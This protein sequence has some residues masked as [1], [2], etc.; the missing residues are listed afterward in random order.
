MTGDPDP[1]PLTQRHAVVTFEQLKGLRAKGYIRDSTLDQRDGFGPD[2]QRRN[3]Q[4]FA[5]SYGLLLGNR[6]YTEFVSGRSVAKR[7]EFQHILEDARL[8]RFDV[9]LVDHTSRFGRNQAECIRYKEEMQRLGKAVV[10]VSQGIISGT[11]RDFL[12]ERINEVL[13]EAYSRNLSRYVKAGFSV[14]ASQGHALGDA[15]LGYRHIKSPSGRGAWAAPDEKTM[16]VLLHLLRSYASGNKS[17]TEVA[18]ELNA[19]GHRTARGNPFTLSTISMVLNNPFYSGRFY[20]HKGRRDQQL[21]EGVHEVT[22]EVRSLWQ[23]C[24]Q[25]R[26]ERAYSTQPSPR[27]KNH[28]VYI[29]TG[30]LVCDNCGQPFHGRSSV[31]HRTPYVRMAHSWRRCGAKPESV[32]APAVEKEFAERVI[33]CIKLDDGWRKAVLKALALEGPQPDRSLE[34][35]RVEAALEN[36]R[37]QHLWGALD[38]QTFSREFRELQLQLRNLQAQAVDHATPNLDRAAHLLQELPAL[39][40]HP[41]VADDHRRSVAREV[42]EEVRLRSGTLVAVK[43]KPAYQPLFAYQVWKENVAS[44]LNSS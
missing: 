37:K 6:W 10:F 42:F 21:I 13:D 26:R 3:E 18:N 12:N 29:L 20:Y 25:V 19:L 31:S 32:S 30:V 11:D 41:G 4:R 2:I 22:E 36:L 28:R 23:K 34:I 38:D 16:P 17:F 15:P 35:K 8:D 39:W 9:L 33:S 24:Q 1:S 44:G 14:K 43:P 27:A 5:E 7:K 40:R